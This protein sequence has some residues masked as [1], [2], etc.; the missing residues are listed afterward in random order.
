MLFEELRVATQDS[1]DIRA[2]L[3]VLGVVLLQCFK[4]GIRDSMEFLLQSLDVDIVHIDADSFH[5]LSLL[6]FEVP[7]FLPY[8]LLKFLEFLT[9]WVVH[10]A[11][12]SPSNI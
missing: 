8:F 6:F 10:N 4:P 3:L 5:F 12:S 11:V 2:I 1:F 9:C 7:Y